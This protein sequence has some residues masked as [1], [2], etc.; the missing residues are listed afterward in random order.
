MLAALERGGFCRSTSATLMNQTSSRSHAVFT[1]FL[2]QHTIEDL[3]PN[4]DDLVM[5]AEDSE[6]KNDQ[7]VYY[8]A[9]S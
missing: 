2:E 4:N 8:H 6:G 7:G 1:I 9:L 5:T 3:Y